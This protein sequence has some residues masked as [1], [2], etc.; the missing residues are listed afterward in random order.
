MLSLLPIAYALAPGPSSRKT[1][2]ANG[3]LMRNA[4]SSWLFMGDSVV[5]TVALVVIACVMLSLFSW[6]HLF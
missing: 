1:I 5:E 2:S 3:G 4:L 6:L